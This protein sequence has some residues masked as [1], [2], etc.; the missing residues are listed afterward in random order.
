MTR[1]RTRAC[2][3]GM[4]LALPFAAC[5]GEAEPDLTMT[6]APMARVFELGESMYVR[7]VISNP[8]GRHVGVYSTEVHLSTDGGKNTRL[9]RVITPSILMQR[10]H[11]RTRKLVEVW[12]I[13][14]G[15]SGKGDKPK[16]AFDGP[17]DV[18]CRVKTEILI[19][20]RP[21]RVR[22]AAKPKRLSL[23]ATCRFK[24]KDKLFK[25]NPP[26]DAKLRCSPRLYMFQTS[27][28][29]LMKAE[30]QAVEAFAWA[31]RDKPIGKNLLWQVAARY[32]Q[33]APLYYVPAKPAKRKAVLAEILKSTAPYGKRPADATEGPAAWRSPLGIK[34]L[35]H[36]L[37]T[38]DGHFAH[39]EPAGIALIRRYLSM[40]KEEEALK[41]STRVRDRLKANSPGYSE[42]VDSLYERISTGFSDMNDEEWKLLQRQPISEEK[43]QER[44]NRQVQLG[45]KGMGNLPAFSA[46]EIIHYI[47]GLCGRL[48]VRYEHR[49]VYDTKIQP[50]AINTDGKMTVREHLKR[51]LSS[52]KLGYRMEDG[53]MLIY[54]LA[55]K[56]A[57]SATDSKKGREF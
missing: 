37:E 18:K 22:A 44:L 23:W 52:A 46:G 33:H 17:A 10:V 9:S 50:E 20:Q 13:D 53:L 12:P 29:P 45:G 34:Y 4:L 1:T 3:A 51:I 19:W 16:A 7:C 30:F 27:G 57:P 26:L 21:A 8:K 48:P 6:A 36:L 5:G 56:K 42:T 2:L 49:R 40:G 55:P 25:Y 31:N 35:T 39:Y 28:I 38:D 14:V 41:W 43:R 11:P 54:R 15:L 47:E 32:V 24:V